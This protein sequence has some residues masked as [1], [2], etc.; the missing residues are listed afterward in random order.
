MK[1]LR[2]IILLCLVYNVLCYGMTVF[3]DLIDEGLINL[4]KGMETLTFI[5][6]FIL[7]PLSVITAEC[8]GFS[9]DF[10]RKERIV[11]TLVWAGISLVIMFTFGYPAANGRIIKQATGKMMNGVEY[12][13]PGLLLCAAVPLLYVLLWIEQE[14]RT[15]WR[16]R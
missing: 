14:I 2:K 13:L 16:N 15:W 5:F 3:Y 1:S 10:S 4:S 6:L 9:R 12:F 11:Y 7:V 8:L